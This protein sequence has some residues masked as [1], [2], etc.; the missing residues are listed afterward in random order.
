MGMLRT[1]LVLGAIVAFMPSPPEDPAA[2]PAAGPGTFG[3]VAAAAETVTDVKGFCARQ[4]FVCQTAGQLA[5]VVERKAKY[6]A[7]LLYEWA[8]E[9]TA[10]SRT[11]PVPADMALTD[12]I[13][14]GSTGP[15]AI[16]VPSVPLD[17][18]I[19][20]GDGLKG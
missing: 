9:A 11:S 16:S 1:T 17:L 7:K 4:P 3:Y 14:T 13:A 18:F 20:P 5:H 10:D 12:L 15:I 8:N 2:P 6:S 19:L